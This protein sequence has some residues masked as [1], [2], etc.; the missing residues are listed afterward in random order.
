[1][2]KILMMM[3]LGITSLGLVGCENVEYKKDVVE[4]ERFT[5]NDYTLESET[6]DVYSWLTDKYKEK[7]FYFAIHDEFSIELGNDRTKTPDICKYEIKETKIVDGIEKE[8]TDKINYK[9]CNN[10][11]IKFTFLIFT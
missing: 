3:V 5:K 11:V 6:R 2:K 1:M 4:L 7:T 8:T 10:Q 9:I